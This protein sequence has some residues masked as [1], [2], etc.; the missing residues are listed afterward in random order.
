MPNADHRPM[1]APRTT[2]ATS[3]A[4]LVLLAACSR[5][6]DPPAAGAAP[7]VVASAPA[8]SVAWLKAQTDTDVDAAFSRARAEGKPVFLY[9]G[10]TWC[11]PCN[12]VKATIFPRADF[13]ER[14]Q[15]FVP[16]YVDGDLPGA[17]KLGERFKVRGYPTMILFRPD[18]SEFTRLPGEV[19]ATRYL[20]VLALGVAE[21]QP[22]AA[23]LPRALAEPGSLRPADWR[24]LAFYSWGTDE[25]QLLPAGRRAQTLQQLA[26]AVPP[27]PA[28][29]AARLRLQAWAAS[30]EPGAGRVAD[31]GP[32]RT[33]LGALLGD[34][35][36]TREQQDILA[37]QGA[38]LVAAL[39]AAGTPERASLQSAM[40]LA[41]V[42]LNADASLSQGDR[43]NALVER[44][45]LARLDAR[46]TALPE[47]LLADVRAE[48]AR[49]GREIGS[50]VERQSVIPSAA[51]ALAQAG[52]LDE[53]DRLLEAE[54]ER[55]HSPYY[56]MLQLASNARK[57]GDAPAALGWY[58]RAYKESTGPAT[59]VQWGAGYVAALIELAPQDS[60]RIERA[61]S[62]VLGELQGQPDAFYARTAR[63]V[64]RMNGKLAA[65]AATRPTQAAR[66]A[67]VKRLQAR[68]DELCLALP[69]GDAQRATCAGLGRTLAG[70]A[71]KAAA[72]A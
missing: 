72:K 32:V 57:R 28:E 51:Y 31:A 23:L 13:I 16:V 56:A 45:A 48:V 19:D 11:P 67:T 26:A 30:H 24:L 44:I 58:E 49:A 8:R 65:W 43:M 33:Q 46:D 20:E 4:L 63:S 66:H 35:A 10:A 21:A 5:P 7:A 38:E 29:V 9:W 17:Q 53:S 59:R 14:S 39:S 70:S 25:Q 64:E 47:A 6:A 34:A 55:S 22:A 61:A 2:A 27:A 41:L 15:G 3:L 60:A 62:S 40:D 1:S 68:L 69:E 36:A 12:Q 54:L 52:L 18:G 71:P 37:N 50:D 42:R